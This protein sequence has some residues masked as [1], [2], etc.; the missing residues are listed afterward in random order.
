MIF[1]YIFLIIVLIL[2]YLRNWK[3]NYKWIC[4]KVALFFLLYLIGLVWGQVVGQVVVVVCVCGTT[5]VHYSW[6]CV[7]TG[8]GCVEDG[9]VYQNV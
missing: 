8:G 9:D 1:F 6:P 4:G 2:Y 7:G 5:K 3:N